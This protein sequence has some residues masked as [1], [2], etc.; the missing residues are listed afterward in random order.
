MRIPEN[1]LRAYC[2]PAIDA[3][4]L[5]HRLTMSGLEVEERAPVA[6]PREQVEAQLVEEQQLGHR[7]SSR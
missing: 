5:E 6:P 1:W 3:G 4:E 2:D 7:V